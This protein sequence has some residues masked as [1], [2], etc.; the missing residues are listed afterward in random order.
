MTTT[1]KKNRAGCFDA[2]QSASTRLLVA[3]LIVFGCGPV[4]ALHTVVCGARDIGSK[5]KRVARGNR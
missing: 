2:A 4:F 5:I 1:R 3:A